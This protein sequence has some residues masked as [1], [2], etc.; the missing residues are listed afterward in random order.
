M[1]VK[2]AKFCIMRSYKKKG[3]YHTASSQ[4][5]FYFI[6]ISVANKQRHKTV[7]K[8][9]N[10][11]RKVCLYPK[12]KE[13]LDRNCKETFLSENKDRI[14]NIHTNVHFLSMCMSLY[15]SVNANHFMYRVTLKMVLL[16]TDFP[17]HSQSVLGRH[18]ATYGYMKT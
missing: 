8:N 14:T 10:I 3:L 16:M 17:T 7:Y 15:K 5:Q 2:G 11:N 1:S 12:I 9:K 18:F 13:I 4:I 6:L